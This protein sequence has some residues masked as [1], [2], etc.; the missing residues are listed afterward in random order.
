MDTWVTS[1]TYFGV[2]GI[3]S[4][5]A[6]APGNSGSA[7]AGV[8]IHNNA[9]QD[10]IIAHATSIGV[11]DSTTATSFAY[12]KESAISV[13]TSDYFAVGST[14]E[15]LGT[16]WNDGNAATLALD[17]T[18]TGNNAYR[19]FKV[20]GHVTNPFNREFAKLDSF[21]ADDGILPATLNSAKPDYNLKI[22]S[23]NATVRTYPSKAA[24]ITVNEI[25]V[26]IFG[27]GANAGT[28]TFKLYYKGEETQDMDESSTSTQVA[29]EI[30]GFSHLSGSV[31]VA[32]EGNNWLVTF[33]AKD[34]DVAEMTALSTAGDGVTIAT[35]AHGWSIEGP[36]GLGLDTMQAGGIVNVTAR[37]V[38]TF[39]YDSAVTDGYFC[40]DGVCGILTATALASANFQTAFDS[41][42]DDNGDQI[43]SGGTVVVAS[44]VVSVT[45]PMGKSCDGLE[46]RGSAK[47]ITK[48]VEKHNNGKQFKITR[49]FLQRSTPAIGSATTSA[50][51]FTRE[52]SLLS[53]VKHVD[54]VI[55]SDGTGACAGKV[56]AQGDE[57]YPIYR[58]I[59]GFGAT[60]NIF[61]APAAAA[62][63]VTAITAVGVITVSDTTANF[64][65]DELI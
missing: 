52:A 61:G 54:S 51:T 42:K 47:A 32:E 12:L 16:T 6:T 17:T 8:V 1:N 30:N 56:D 9:A 27:T 14:V 7:A 41:V 55:I 15:V 65:P 46:L 37:E 36:V 60:A 59:D 58:T 53:A 38:C 20:T 31:S 62:G 39:T 35:R 5:P 24:Q 34:G 3:S 11:Q 57:S 33:D 29:E 63:D 4:A 49:S 44:L 48:T 13:E 40:Y 28:G 18:N 22:T 64:K 2:G 45:M 26:V 10:S 43:L 23:N 19:K 25:Q 21:P 50:I